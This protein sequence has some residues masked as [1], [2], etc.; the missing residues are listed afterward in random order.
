M[1]LIKI[2]KDGDVILQESGK[3]GKIKSR[4]LTS[5]KEYTSSYL[6]I[7]DD[8]KFVDVLKILFKDKKFFNT[9][10]KSE[11]NGL[12]LEYIEEEIKKETEDSLIE[13]VNSDLLQINRVFSV[14]KVGSET[15]D[16]E[17]ILEGFLTMHGVGYL[18]AEDDIELGAEAIDIKGPSYSE[19]EEE[20][21]DDDEE[22]IDHSGVT[23][24]ISDYPVYFLKDHYICINNYIRMSCDEMSVNDKGENEVLIETIWEGFSG[25]TVYEV[26]KAIIYEICFYG[27]T[28]EKKERL[29]KLKKDYEESKGGG[30][31]DELLTKESAVDAILRDCQERMSEAI[32]RE[33]YEEAGRLKNKISKLKK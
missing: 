7:E 8:V 31:N 1:S 28:E 4:K 33:D 32:R 25:V 21:E 3:N 29:D 18:V 26:L 13:G 16:E 5:V 17:E 9:L 27:K 15:E 30:L 22:E 2:T 20:D 19:E 23:F 10:F 14:R 6:E 24:F 12:T 11:L